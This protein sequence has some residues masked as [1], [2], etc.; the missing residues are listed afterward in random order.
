MTDLEERLIELCK[1][2]LKE[3]AIRTDR[4][5]PEP[6]LHNLACQVAEIIHRNVT[7]GR[8]ERVWRYQSTQGKKRSGLTP[9]RYVDRVIEHYEREHERI[10]KLGARDDEEWQTLFQ[11]L[12]IRAYNKLLDFSISKGRAYS[13]AYDLAQEACEAIFRDT[14]PYDVAFDAW[15]TKI[16]NNRILRKYSRSSEPMDKPRLMQSIDEIVEGDTGSRRVLWFILTSK[17]APRAFKRVENREL[18]FQAIEQLKSQAQQQVVM[19]SFL[20][21]ESDEEIAAKLGKTKQAIYNLRHRALVKLKEILS[22]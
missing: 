19:R 16:L 7:S 10:H 8:V 15:A 22:R 21:G 17:E 2:R 18:L 11:Q 12:V 14:Y 20:L 5:L 3:S 4:Q 13:E 9:A 6:T 1:S